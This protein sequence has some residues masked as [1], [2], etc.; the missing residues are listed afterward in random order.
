MLVWTRC[1]GRC[2]FPGKGTLQQYPGT[3]NFAE[4]QD[5]LDFA[6]EPLTPKL[7]PA[8][9]VAPPARRTRAR[10]DSRMPVASAVPRA[11]KNN[12]ILKIAMAIRR[13][14]G[15][16]V[17]GIAALLLVALIFVLPTLIDA[18]RYRPQV[19]SYLQGKTGKQ[20]EIGRLALTFF[21]PSIRIDNFGLKNPRLFPPGYIVK[22]P[23]I[24]AELRRPLHTQAG[25]DGQYKSET[26]GLRRGRRRGREN[27]I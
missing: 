14:A 7:V 10:I 6:A 24:D 8:I 12:C 9:G 3:L 15:L 11:S 23:R 1:C 19:V 20:V 18:D 26:D 5:P 2:R 25:K 17:G 13:K 16:I 27:R 22:V 21:P 4:L